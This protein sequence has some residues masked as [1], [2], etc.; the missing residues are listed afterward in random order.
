MIPT[1]PAQDQ[2]RQY[3]CPHPGCGPC[4]RPG[5]GPIV[6]RSWTGKDK[7]LARGRGTP[8]R[9][10][11]SARRG[12]LMAATQ[13]PDETVERLLQCQRWGVCDAGTADLGAGDLKTGHRCQ[14]VAAHRAHE[15]PEPVTP[16]RRGE[17]VQRDA[18]HATRRGPPGAW[19]HT[20]LARRRRC[21]RWGHWGPR[22]QER[23]ALRSAQ[24]VA[25]RCGLPVW[26]SAGGNASPAALGP[27]LGRVDQR[28]RRGR[29]GRHPT[30]RVVP[31]RD[32]C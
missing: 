19:R 31:P 12:T 18:R 24:V 1:T 4:N 20:A 15:Q 7:R 9:H 5:A 11:C 26:R 25:R 21:G 22:P 14:H 23:A 3:A 30:P 32:R 8:W 28:R 27:G 29:D 10:A 17:G 6:H 13:R 16:A 2:D